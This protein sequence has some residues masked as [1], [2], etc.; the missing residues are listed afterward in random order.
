MTD[1]YAHAK[2]IGHTG[3]AAPLFE[4]AGLSRLMDD[5]F[6]SL[7][8]TAA[9]EFISRCAQLRFWPRQLRPAGVQAR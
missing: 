9:A 6:V 5:G 4:A 3:A 1:A 2:F 7:D 8:Q